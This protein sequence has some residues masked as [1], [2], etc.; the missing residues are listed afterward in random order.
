MR[1]SGFTEQ[2]AVLRKRRK[3]TWSGLGGTT[4]TYEPV[5][6]ALQ[7]LNR[8]RFGWSGHGRSSLHG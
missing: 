5:A 6:T 3:A 7:D 4:N 1:D 2:W 8:V